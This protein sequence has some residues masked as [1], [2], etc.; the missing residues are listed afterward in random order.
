[1]KKH[2]KVYIQAFNTSSLDYLACPIDS[3]IH[4]IFTIGF[5]DPPHFTCH[6]AV[7][8]SNAATTLSQ[9]QYHNFST[10]ICTSIFPQRSL[11]V[12]MQS[13]LASGLDTWD[14]CIASAFSRP[15]NFIF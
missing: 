11:F 12:S 14:N 3:L 7:T 5:L 1:M 9:Q 15:K 8:L 6:D 10:M 4:P 2:F 13:F